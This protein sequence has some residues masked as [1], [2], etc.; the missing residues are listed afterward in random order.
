MRSC[1]KYPLALAAL[2]A[3]VSSARAD[4][5]KFTD[6]SSGHVYYTDRP[7]HSGYRLLIKT[8]SGVTVT[9]RELEKN[10]RLYAPVIDA[11]A[12]KYGLDPA[13]LHAVIRAESGYN[14]R[15]VSPKGAVGL[16]QLMPDTAS[17]Y[18]VSDRHDPN[19]NIEGGARYLRDLIGMFGAN[20][21]LVV[22]AYNA[23]ENAVIRHGN[24]IPPYP[25]TQE[26]VSRVLGQYYR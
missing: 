18:G 7:S 25:E 16:M 12:S 11:V 10:R 3:A 1:R 24:Q 14:S 9:Y 15:A 6:R 22:A 20:L 8:F 26:Y 17:R 23:G 13:L 21:K 2:L 5:Y 4:V 19:A